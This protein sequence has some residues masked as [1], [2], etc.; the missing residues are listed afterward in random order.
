[1]STLK[2]DAQNVIT[3][4]LT[5]AQPKSAVLR[6]LAGLNLYGGKLRVVSIGKAAWTMAE[7]AIEGLGARIDQ[8]LAVVPY[9]YSRGPLPRFAVMEAGYPMPDEN[10]VLAADAAIAMTQGLD[11]EDTVLMLVSG[12]G[13]S[14]LERPLVPLPLYA[15]TLDA[16]NRCG[17]SITETNLIRKRLSAVKGGRFAK[18]CAP[19]GVVG[20]LL[21]DVLG[22]APETIAS[23]PVS[24]DPIA[25]DEAESTLLRLLPDAPPLIRALMRRETPK[26]LPNAE[27]LLIGNVHVLVRSAARALRRL[28][29]E[30]VVLTDR[31]NCEAREAGRFLASIALSHQGETHSVAYLAGGETTVRVCG[32]GQGGRNQELALAAAGTLE[33]LHNT[34]LFSLGSDGRDGPTDAAGAYVDHRTAGRL[35]AAQVD[36]AAALRNNDSYNALRAAGALIK[37]GPTGTSV[38]DISAVLIRR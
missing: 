7:A 2:E 21:S 13:S 37:T 35:R 3:A 6:A 12:G 1:L 19:A 29:Y 8:G 26:E 30:T 15:T 20:L 25:S 22:D 23:G 32:N 4:A 14:L 27:T 10:S 28:G 36:T 18:L 34:V 11:V 33:G 31:L 17:A 5:A 9:G 16:L 38:N 24:P